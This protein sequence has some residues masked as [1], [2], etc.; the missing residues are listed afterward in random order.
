ML[1][2]SFSDE[3]YVS[4]E[5]LEAM[6]RAR[7]EVHVLAREG[8]RYVG[9]QIGIHN[10]RGEKVGRPGRLRN[11]EFLFLAAPH[12]GGLRLPEAWRYSAA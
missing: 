11:T 1:I 5:E 9:A 6:L 12:G 4:R 3:G 8:R 10:P 2:V 7:G